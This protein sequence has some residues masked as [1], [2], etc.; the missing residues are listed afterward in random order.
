MML[1][2][3]SIARS[4]VRYLKNL[5]QCVLDTLKQLLDNKRAKTAIYLISDYK[6]MGYDV[7]PAMELWRN[8][9]KKT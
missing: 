8:Y 2:A 7:K 9:Y 1:K 3:L 4:A 6:F 5:E